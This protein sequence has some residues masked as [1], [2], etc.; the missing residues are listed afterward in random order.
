MGKQKRSFWHAEA[1]RL[2]AD[3]WP[4]AAIAAKMGRS[5]SAVKNA[6]LMTRC[7]IDHRAVKAFELMQAM[8]ADPSFRVANATRSRQRMT[9]QRKDREF[10]EKLA[11]GFQTYR[12]YR[13][14]RK[15]ELCAVPAAVE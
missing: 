11:A 2:K 3:G 9:T 5:V 6:T 13:A 1:N 4:A 14:R 15:A 10:I 7:P 8:N 12:G